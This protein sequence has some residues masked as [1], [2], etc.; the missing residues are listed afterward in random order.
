MVHP[1][2]IFDEAQT[3]LLKLLNNVASYA[4]PIFIDMDAIWYIAT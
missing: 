2:Q 4:T 3:S 1:N